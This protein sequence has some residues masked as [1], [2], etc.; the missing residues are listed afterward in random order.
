M[1]KFF[2][3]LPIIGFCVGGLG[4]LIGAGG[5]FLLVPILF[6]LYPADSPAT[7]TFISLFVVCAN[8]ASGTVSYSRM[9]RIDYR[10]GLLFACAM[11]IPAV[12]GV[13]AVH[14]V[15]R[16]LFTLVFGSALVLAAGW[17]I[18]RPHR[19]RSAEEVAAAPPKAGCTRRK[20]TDARG[21][22]H[23]YEFHMPVA[24]S[25]SS[26]IGS[27]SSFLGIGGGIMHVPF[28]S[29]VLKFPVHVA[30]ATS[31]F[32]LAISSFVAV[33]THFAEGGT[34]P[35]LGRAIPAA[36]G[37][38]V[39]SQIGARLSNRVSGAK[40]LLILAFALAFVGTRMIWK[41]VSG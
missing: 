3:L 40:I 30:T 20:F 4:T 11:I 31:Q 22:E 33:C 15:D 12:L 2:L 8:A 28:M 13:Y 5:G 26:V 19:E 29:R 17:L 1:D 24:V 36:V 18:F 38:I 35:A 32:L 7:F 10:S 6:F 39:G 16:R 23:H 21:I 25:V 14:F 27:I 37:A 41:A 9:K 34:V